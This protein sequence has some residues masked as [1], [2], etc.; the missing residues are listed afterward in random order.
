MEVV[1]AFN[2]ELSSLYECKPPISK[3]KMTQVTKAAIKGIKFYKHIVQ[4]VEKFVQKCRAEYKVPGLYVIDSIVRQSRHQFGCEK[5]VFAPRFTKNITATFQNLFKCPFEDRPKIVRVLNLWQKN[6]VFPSEVIQPLLDMA[7]PNAPVFQQT[8]PSGN[9]NSGSISVKHKGMDSAPWKTWS[10]NNQ[11]SDS[12]LTES[13][14]FQ[15]S[16]EPIGSEVNK[17]KNEDSGTHLQVDTVLLTRLQEIAGQ[18]LVTKTEETRAEES[19]VKFNKVSIYIFNCLKVLL[20]FLLLKVRRTNY[21][22]IIN[23]I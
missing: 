23:L 1:R 4:S 18:L 5:D 10:Q 21:A 8:P 3:A 11:H 17:I 6:N 20:H 19:T 9:D 14:S 22:M 13:H 16:E 2:N 12:A 7:N 15:N